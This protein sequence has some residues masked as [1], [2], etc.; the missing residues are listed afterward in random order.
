[1][2]DEIIDQYRSGELEGDELERARV[3]F[4]KSEARQEKLRFAIALDE[5]RHRVS[6]NGRAAVK[7]AAKATV[8]PIDSHIDSRRR[9]FTQ[10][11]AI[12]AV[13]LVALGIGFFVWRSLR[14]QSQSDLDRGLVAFQAAYRD[15]RPVAVRLSSL[16]Y[17]PLPN[18]RGGAPKVNELQL[19]L[20]EASL[21]K[22]I[23][24][25]PNAAAPHH[26]LG[27]CYVAQHQF[28]K[29][30]RELKAALAL[31]PQNAKIHSDLGAALLEQ[32][33]IQQSGPDRGK[34][35]ETFGESQQH[36]D[37]AIELNP[38]LLD[39]YFNRAL[40]RQHMS[41]GIQAITGWLE[42]LQKD[43]TSPWA[44]EARRNLANIEAEHGSLRTIRDDVKDLLQARNEG[45]DEAA[46]RLI[47]DNYTTA[48]N[49]LTNY[50]LDV[51]LGIERA[52]VLPD[53]N[54]ALSGLELIARLEMNRS[55]DRY[56]LDLVN[57]LSRAPP[58]ETAALVQA[59]RHMRL[60]Y[61]LFTESNYRKAIEEYRQA[62]HAYEL[63]GTKSGVTFVEYR[64]AHS[65]VFLPDFEEARRGLERLMGVCETNHYRWLFANCLFS[66][67]HV[68]A[69]SY[70]YS[71]ALEYSER[72]MTEFERIDDANGIVKSLTQFADSNQVLNRLGR[73]LSYLN[74]ALAVA[75]TRRV[76]PMQRWGLLSQI[77][78]CMTLMKAYQAAL[79]Y[80][81]EALAIAVELKRP[82]PISRSHSYLSYAYTAM[83][84]FSEA[85]DQARNAFNVGARLP[86]RDD[87]YDIMA[88][89]SLQLGDIRRAAGDCKGA[90]EEYDSSLKYYA[91]IN[92][93]YYSYRAYKGKLDCF[94]ANSDQAAVEIELQKALRVSEQYRSKI[95]TE[96][97]RNSFFDLLQGVYDL[98]I[99]HKIITNDP[100][101][102]FEYSEESKGRSL[103]DAVQRGTALSGKGA[104]IEVKLE[105]VAR[106]VSEPEIRKKM[107]RNTQILQYAV[108]DDRVV[109]WLVTNAG[110]QWK[111][112]RITSPELGEKVKSYLETVIHPPKDSAAYNPAQ[113]E[114]L[115]GILI[116]PVKD[117][118]NDAEPLCI[119]P[120]KI[121]NFVPFAA[122]V[123]PS[124]KKFL[125]QDYRLC[126]APSSSVFVYLTDA[127]DRK[128]G[129]FEEKLLSVGNP[130][131]DRQRFDSLQDLPASVG[132]AREVARSY[133]NPKLLVR[134]DARESTI[135]SEIET[136]DVGHF[137]MHYVI[138][139]QSEM[140]SG[141]PLTPEDND[142]SS[143][144]GV[145]GFLQ[146]HEIYR[147]NLRRMRL[148]VLSACSTGIER[149]Y[150]GE[151]AV[152][153]VRSFLMRGVPTA[154]ASL[155]PV[156]SDA[157]AEL[158]VSFHKNRRQQ[159]EPVVQA[160]RDAQIG[161]LTATDKPTQ[162]H[163]YY[164]AP[165][166]VIGG[167]SSY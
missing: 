50:L 53:P 122:L 34:E 42:Y 45:N 139:E 16:N 31:D 165:F 82:L 76:E 74:Q 142:A 134:D 89:A 132:E 151:G 148:V 69:D 155:W 56:T 105:S 20:A 11:L 118:L 28:E 143:E 73:S 166:V 7:S 153:A 88:N 119:V 59:R 57:H 117:L 130:N 149:Q 58:K 137:A 87:G 52:E 113:A 67:A 85:T 40:L 24:D 133:Q 99:T 72:A 103:L 125:I 111:E 3:Y 100:L 116:A 101:K 2:V 66:L 162:H 135:R 109:M 83:Q 49:T 81:K 154:V 9:S 140:L 141:F 35:F 17:A 26:A 30:L 107:P 110:L 128:V 68:S 70:E 47:G 12:A 21:L 136:A 4:F 106:A 22:A 54:D 8:T 92:F 90:V 18:Q 124:S 19:D 146:A 112:S 96:S 158:M 108:L 150:R 36:L 27:Q 75:S 127:A 152:G 78:I 80:H 104:N 159:S 164:W 95:R 114:E 145:N 61:T 32:G 33:V 14:P 167:L 161:M 77:G 44:D 55:D 65:Y 13:V 64:L 79:F 144:A 23:S 60:A 126:I 46:W 43:S 6:D 156:D 63:A 39:A 98:A 120:D 94:M 102:A 147:L 15:E 115:F 129:K 71:K 97:Q 86:N 29:A 1:M 160:L 10:Y 163:P 48:G 131:F 5:S 123:S 37:K 91:L 38:S 121:L 138:N 51:H 25:N 41:P 62:K 157:T 93:S 84:M